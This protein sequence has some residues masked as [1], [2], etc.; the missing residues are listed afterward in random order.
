MRKTRPK[1][2]FTIGTMS[3]GGAER[4]VSIISNYLIDRG[5]DVRILMWLH[6]PVFYNLNK[7][8]K[9]IDVEK[10]CGSSNMISRAIFFRN[11][12][13]RNKP[14]LLLSF[15]A[16]INILTLL[17]CISIPVKIIACERNDPRFVPFSKT[18]RIVRN[19]TYYLAD[20]ILTQTLKNKNYF[21]TKLEP[22]INVIYNP[23]NINQDLVGSAINKPKVKK[24]VAVG[25]LVDQKN[26][27]MLIKAFSSF[28][29]T[30]PAYDLYIYGEGP[31]LKRHEN[32][33]YELGIATHVIFPGNKKDIFY[34]ISDAEI[35]VQTSRFEGMPNTLI[36]AMCLGLPCIST[37]VSG[38]TDLIRH[39]ENGFLV[40]IDDTKGLEYYILKLVNDKRLQKDIGNNA[41]RLYDTLKEDVIL[42]QW[43]SYILSQINLKS[44]GN[45]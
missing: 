27:E 39:G 36:E 37:K 24:I 42:K 22:R 25:R 1:I 21:S 15:L 5:Y 31:N 4:V 10:E 3:S 12:I 11:Y 34:E 43:E 14:D 2:Y 45:G 41:S 20:G 23:I 19:V 40:D 6:C 44:I 13:K 35:F 17:S 32:M 38:A 16:K 33:A 30:Y 28:L 18:L 26:H 9:I 8:I 29:K 7:K